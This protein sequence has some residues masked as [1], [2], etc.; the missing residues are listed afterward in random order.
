[1]RVPVGGSRVDR[2][3]GDGSSRRNVDGVESERV[4]TAGSS[5]AGFGDEINVAEVGVDDG[6]GDD[7]GSGVG[8]VLKFL[9][10]Y[11][12]RRREWARHSSAA[13]KLVASVS[14]SMA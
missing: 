6:S 3:R 13:N 7:A 9:C 1:V 14:A 2:R 5:V 10:R 11:R 4:G 12:C 8:C